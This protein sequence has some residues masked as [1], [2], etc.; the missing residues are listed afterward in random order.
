M[1]CKEYKPYP[2]WHRFGRLTYVSRWE[3]H[4]Q[5]NWDKRVVYRLKC[6]CWKFT[7]VQK[8]GLTDWKIQSCWCLRLE[9]LIKRKT[10][11]WLRKHP[12][13]IIYHAMKDRC[14]NTNDSAYINYWWRDITICDEWIWENWV[15]NFINDMWK[16]YKKW[17][18]IDR[19]DNNKWYSKEN[20]KR[21]NRYEQSNNRRNNIFYDYKGKR[22]PRLELAEYVW[23][24]VKTIDERIKR[25]R[26][27]ERACSIP[28][29]LYHNKYTN[30][31]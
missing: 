23:I 9:L 16:D 5:P 7:E 30:V 11:H 25:W 24:P 15:V 1:L 3:D 8:Y 31:W 19:I 21:S 17:L 20:C 29:N 27:I 13:Y 26:S 22:Y 4:T 12:L 10:T 28:T 2:I 18:S 6:D 14:Y